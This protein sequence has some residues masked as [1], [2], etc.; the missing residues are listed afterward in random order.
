MPLSAKQ[1]AFLIGLGITG[2]VANYSALP[3]AASSPDEFYWC[4]ASEGSKWNPFVG[5]YKPEGLYYSNGVS[6]EYMA[7]AY[8]ATQADV[9]AGTVTDQ[10][11]SPATLASFNVKN[12]VIGFLKT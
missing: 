2:V 8:Q 7:S 12:T 11:V 3:A 5:A 6:W 10:F 9:D 4:Q 1:A